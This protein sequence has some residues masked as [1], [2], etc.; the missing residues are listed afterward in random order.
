MKNEIDEWKIFK[1][2]ILDKLNTNKIQLNLLEKNSNDNILRI[3]KI[4]NNTVLYPRLIGINSKFKSFHEYIDYTVEQLSTADNFRNKMD[5]DLKYFK[6]KIDKIIQA[7]KLK[8]ETSIYSAN[9]LVQKRIKENENL[10][11][12]YINSK[13]FDMLIK[14]KE[15]E[16][17]I[18]KNKNESNSFIYNINNSLNVRIE[19]EIEKIEEEKKL[20]YKDLNECKNKITDLKNEIKIN[21]KNKLCKEEYKADLIEIIRNIMEEELIPKFKIDNLDKKDKFDFIHTSDLDNNEFNDRNKSF[22]LE[23]KS[24]KNDMELFNKNIIENKICYDFKANRTNDIRLADSKKSN[25]EQKI[26][27]I[28]EIRKKYKNIKDL[29]FL[30]NEEKII[31]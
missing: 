3:D 6:A 17:I 12:D 31:K 15:I 30:G 1:N 14:S 10:I 9:Q 19:K 28:K 24:K 27:N 2:E 18:E 16:N 21:E 22:D 26:T 20:I 5:L 8:I 23:I 7:L 13:I 4:L 11:K 25:N 29:N